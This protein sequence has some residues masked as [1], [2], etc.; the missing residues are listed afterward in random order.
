VSESTAVD[1]LNSSKYLLEIVATD[2][3]SER[4]LLNIAEELTTFEILHH[5][6]GNFDFS[7]VSSDLFPVN[8][9]LDELNDVWVRQLIKHLSFL[10]NFV[11][12]GAF[13]ILLFENLNSH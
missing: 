13:L 6:V 8:F 9:E 12:V 1:V 3:L 10:F 11:Q 5:D 7:T 4:S 2:L